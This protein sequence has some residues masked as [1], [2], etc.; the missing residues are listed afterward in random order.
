MSDPGSSAAELGI[1]DGPTGMPPHF[2]LVLARSDN[3]TD[4][5]GRIGSF[6]DH[7]RG[8]AEAAT[9]PL[10]LFKGTLSE[11][12]I[13]APAFLN[14]PGLRQQGRV[15]DT[16]LTVM[17]VLP[18]FLEIAKT[19]HPGPVTYNG[20]QIQGVA[21]RSFWGV[22]TGSSETVHGQDAVGWSLRG[23]GALIRGRYKL[24]NQP[25]DGRRA[26]K[27]GSRCPPCGTASS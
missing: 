27:T 14:Y 21:G 16:F 11:G 1:V 2:D 23:R 9:A 12:G 8:F 5:I 7:G 26:A 6:V 25:H 24:T 3:R 17:D 19:A 13:R 20:R 4:N 22:L 10:R 15:N 18:T